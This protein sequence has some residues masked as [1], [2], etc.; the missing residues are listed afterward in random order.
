MRIWIRVAISVLLIAA[1]ACAGYFI[2]RC[3]GA[4]ARNIGTEAGEPDPMFA[5]PAETV[6]RPPELDEE[7]IQ[8]EHPTLDDYVPAEESPVDK[9]VDELIAEA[10]NAA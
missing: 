1:L 10:K 9:T 5:E 7:E 3:V 4:V 6:T 8:P 2:L